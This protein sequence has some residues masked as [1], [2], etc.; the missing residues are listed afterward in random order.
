MSQKYHVII[1]L[2][3]LASG[4][5]NRFEVHGL[6]MTTNWFKMR[7]NCA[8]VGV[9]ARANSLLYSSYKIFRFS[10]GFLANAYEISDFFYDFSD[11]IIGISKDL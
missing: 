4:S 10:K 2:L 6:S 1:M 11:F 9:F 8:K 3:V 5:S 7:I